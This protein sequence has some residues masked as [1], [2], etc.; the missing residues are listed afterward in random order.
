[1]QGLLLF[2]LKTTTL[3]KMPLPNPSK[4]EKQNAFVSRC[5][6]FVMKDKP[7]TDQKQAVAMCFT[8]WRRS[9][10]IENKEEIKNTIEEIK[11]ILKKH[12]HKKKNG[13]AKY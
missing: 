3:Y 6:S 7:S 8:Q 5:V 2:S 11:E 10:K 12:G 13:N 1:M 9:K 4:N